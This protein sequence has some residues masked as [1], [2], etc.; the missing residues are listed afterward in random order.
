MNERIAKLFYL[1]KYL[2]R[3]IVLVYLA[4][5]LLRIHKHIKMI[6]NNILLESYC[7]SCVYIH[8]LYR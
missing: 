4:E 3:R 8:V 5:C 1:P 2:V 6:N 7:I